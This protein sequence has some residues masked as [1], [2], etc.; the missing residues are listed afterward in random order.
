M[1]RFKPFPAAIMNTRTLLPK[2]GSICVSPKHLH[3]PLWSWC[4]PFL[5]LLWSCLL[6]SGNHHWANFEVT[7]EWKTFSYNFLPH[8]PVQDDNFYNPLNILATGLVLHKER[9]F[10]ATPKL[11]SGV[12]S[13]VNWIPRIDFDQSPVLQVNITNLFNHYTC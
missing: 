5:W 11:F 9:I 13:T 4:H 12:P 6:A 3:H 10:I 1:R 8:A 7:K 2:S